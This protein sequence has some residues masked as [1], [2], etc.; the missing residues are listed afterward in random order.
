[1][2]ITFLLLN[3]SQISKLKHKTVAEK[4][5]TAI[6][7]PIRDKEKSTRPQ[8]CNENYRQLMNV[9]S[10]IIFPR[11]NNTNCLSNMKSSTWKHVYFTLHSL[12]GYIYGCVLY[13]K[14]TY[15][16]A[17]KIMDLK[18]EVEVYGRVWVEEREGKVDVLI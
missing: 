16:Y 10:R 13:Y 2:F 4:I 12:A 5:T 7:S 11:E 18:K 3:I 15:V 8:P 14:C 6:D 9:E 17:T 1:M